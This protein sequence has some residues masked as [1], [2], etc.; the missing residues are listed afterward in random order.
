MFIKKSFSTKAKRK[1]PY[2]QIVQS[3]REDGKVKHRVL[4]NLGALSEVQI[5]GLI[6]SLNR[7][8]ESP[9]PLDSLKLEHERQFR[10]GDC[11]LVSTLWHRLEIG[12]AIQRLVANT[13]VGFDV[14]LCTQLMVLN[15]CV[16]PMSKLALTEWQ[17]TVYFEA[18]NSFD[19]HQILRTL[20]YLEKIRDELEGVLF[21]KQ[22]D[23]FRQSVDLVFF[24]V[25]STYF[26]GEGPGI[27]ERGHS[28]DGKP[29]NNQ[30]IL[31]L[32]I[33]KGGLP[34]G[35]EIYEGS[36]KDSQ[37]VVDMLERLKGRF[38]IDQCIFIGDR[39]MVSP[40]NIAEL[41]RLNYEY[42][43]ALR[44]RHLRESAAVIEPDLNRYQELKVDA[45]GQEITKLKYLEVVK[46]DLRYLVCHNPKVAEEELARLESKLAEKEAA[47]QKIL[48]GR[49]PSDG[50]LKAIARIWNINR[51]FLYGLRDGKVWYQP[52]T[53]ALEQ[54]RL[55]AGKFVLKS[56]NRSLSPVQ[57]IEAY[58]NLSEIERAFRT[59]KSFVE[60]RPMYHRSESRVRGHV[61]VCVLAYYIQKVID[62]EL[63]RASSPYS[64][65]K[66]IE[67]LGEIRLIENVLA[68]RRFYQS[69]TLGPEHKKILK[70]LKIEPM[71]E[72]V[73]KEQIH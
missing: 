62:Q 49:R 16:D 50:M 14:A 19:Y 44:K 35:H 51:Y 22:V 73:F 37:T 12:Q 15:R 3:Y 65:L 56:S 6:R 4:A 27:A 41:E 36:R 2:Y 7:L 31:A 52:H 30:I 39:G 68:G 13:K 60:I 64:A 66:A 42:I 24:D 8:K 21:H 70:A 29:E 28:Q 17:K 59:I 34:I 72:A 33:T 58:K 11:Y 20:D 32:A 10:Y 69:I 53:K 47:I 40:D 26:E 43:F 25:T 54:E 46:G 9:Y 67:K 57:I 55:V 63:K 71:P 61:L 23:L 45:A 18:Q 48:Q 1:I 5:D 38:Q